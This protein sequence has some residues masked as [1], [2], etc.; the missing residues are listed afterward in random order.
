[1][2]SK[3]IYPRRVLCLPPDYALW[4]QA[5]AQFAGCPREAVI[6]PALREGVRLPHRQDFA[7]AVPRSVPSLPRQGRKKPP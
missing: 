1:M 3:S 2:R 6:C 5:A 7:R 4:V